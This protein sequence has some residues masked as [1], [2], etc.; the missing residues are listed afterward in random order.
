MQGKAKRIVA[1]LVGVAMITT[2]ASSAWAGEYCSTYGQVESHATGGDY[3]GG[4]LAYETMGTVTRSDGS[5]STTVTT[6]STIS[7]APSSGVTTTVTS[8]T[9][10]G[11]TTTS[12]QEP[13]GVYNMNDG[14]VWEINCLTGATRKVGD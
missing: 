1:A 7:I 4:I 11:T 5:T 14:T 3:V 6:S 12:T 2:P 9:T 10:S 13:I 8:T